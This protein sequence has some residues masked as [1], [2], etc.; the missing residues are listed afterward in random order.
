MA[1]TR[2]VVKLGTQVV[3]RVEGS[4]ALGPLGALVEQVHGLKQAGHDVILV[5]SGAVGAGMGCL[6]LEKRPENV[7]S[8]QAVAAVGQS[9]LMH[10]YDFAFQAHHLQTA[11][12]C[13]DFTTGL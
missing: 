11:Q 2:V 7:A 3:S 13:F 5:S 1:N 8:L 12:V 10:H 6:G 9:K 4:L